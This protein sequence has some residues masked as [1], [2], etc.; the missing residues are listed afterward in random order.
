MQGVKN[1]VWVCRTF[2]KT[3]HGDD[4]TQLRV[5]LVFLYKEVVKGVTIPDTLWV[6]LSPD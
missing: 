3:S 6:I 2:L 4:V 5:I 1:F